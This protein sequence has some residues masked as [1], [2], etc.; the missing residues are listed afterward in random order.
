MKGLLFFA[1]VLFFVSFVVAQQRQQQ[2][3]YW[4]KTSLDNEDT[5]YSSTV[6]F[7][8]CYADVCFYVGPVSIV[9]AVQMMTY[10]SG[11]SPWAVSLPDGTLELIFSDTKP[12]VE[13][14]LFVTPISEFRVKKPHFD[15]SEY[16]DL[17]HN[18]DVQKFVDSI[19]EE[20]LEK[21]VVDL[22]EKFHTRNSFSKEAVE[23]AHYI[24]GLLKDLDCEDVTVSDF[25]T[26]YAPNVRCTI[27]GKTKPDE[28]VVLGAHYDDRAGSN[29][30]TT[31]RAPGADDN[32]TGSSALLDILWV[33]HKNKFEFER[34]LVFAFFAGEEQGLFGSA[35]MAA[36]FNKNATMKIHA[37]INMDMIGFPQ[38]NAPTTLYWMNRATTPSLT[39]LAMELT[40][41][42]LGAETIVKTT[43]GCCSDQSSFHKY[44][45]ASASIFEALSGT[46]NPNYHKSSDTASTITWS[47]VERNT[48]AVSALIAT[49]AV[50][51]RNNN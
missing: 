36:K 8:G 2:Q 24:E 42:Y 29:S 17:E 27:T 35:A 23:A 34:S 31:S 9:D 48:K 4:F 10:N 38:K 21:V 30:N 14:S 37:M 7:R 19:K 41:T 32:A 45:I 28:Y 20:R 3:H 50:V 43:P 22:S 25:K 11:E 26:G 12:D 44:G 51:H 49:V 18:P 40:K 6:D 33:A 5:L 1:S 47:H 15:I 13:S 39:T 46:N 16:S